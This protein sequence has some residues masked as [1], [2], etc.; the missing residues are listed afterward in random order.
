MR[1]PE[2]SAEMPFATAVLF[3][4]IGAVLSTLLIVAVIVPAAWA[5]F[6]YRAALGTVEETRKTRTPAKGGARIGLEA[7]VAFDVA[8]RT[9][10]AW[11]ALPRT[12]RERDGTEVEKVRNQAAVGQRLTCYYDP[13]HPSEGVVLER[14]RF[15]WRLLFGLLFTSLFLLV[16]VAVMAT[17]WRETFP[18]GVAVEAADLLGRLPRRFFLTAAAT[19]LLAVAGFA[20]LSSASGASI[21]F[22]FAAAAGAVWMFKRAGRYASVAFPSPERRAAAGFDTAKPPLPVG[23]PEFDAP[24]AMP[25]KPPS[26]EPRDSASKGSHPRSPLPHARP[27]RLG[28]PITSTRSVGALF[29]IG[30]GGLVLAGLGIQAAR[31][32]ELGPGAPRAALLIV[33]V[34]DALA[35]LA[36]WR[37]TA[38]RVQ[39][40]SVRASNSAPRPGDHVRLEIAH[41]D[42]A[43]LRRLRL[44]LVCEEQ[45]DSRGGRG[46]RTTATHVESGPPIAIGPPAR[47][48]GTWLAVLDIPVGAAP[49]L[50]LEN[51]RILWHLSARLGGWLPWSVRYPLTI[52][53]PT[54]HPRPDV[55]PRR[56]AKDPPA[57]VDDDCV[58]LWIDGDGSGF[59][60]GATLTG[61][62]EVHPRDGRPLRSAELSVL[63]Y[64]TGAGIEELGVAHYEGREAIDGDD[65]ALYSSRGFSVRL[66]LSPCSYLG[67]LVKI[68]WAARVRLRYADGEEVVREL[69]FSLGK[70]ES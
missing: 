36:F 39:G 4:A 1:A 3:A 41:D 22:V 66:P 67:K 12:A 34:L 28:P 23:D 33:F 65:L 9:H 20:G 37:R 27:V 15:D 7:W 55:P 45:A 48:D 53:E 11:A 32:A 52:E 64:T 21:L 26:R 13:L 16:G 70:A 2:Q 25:A 51:H 6:G 18:R 59:P 56:P 63:W 29:A 17:R 24:P 19:V 69:P 44:A 30:L 57:Q 68:R 43:E 40:L 10:R 31:A 42:P 49:S 60:L 38:R 35:L 62:Y 8:G 50:A 14:P 46:G 47:S 61:G 5:R 58:L 54:P